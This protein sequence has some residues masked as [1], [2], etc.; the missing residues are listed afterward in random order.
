[1]HRRD[2]R[3]RRLVSCTRA[4]DAF[5]VYVWESASG[6]LIKR[7]SGEEAYGNGGCGSLDALAC[8]LEGTRIATATKLGAP[9]RI[10]T[11]T[12]AW[13]YRAFA[14][15]FEELHAN[16][17]YVER[18][19]EFDSVVLNDERG[20]GGTESIPSGAAEAEAVD[21]LRPHSLDEFDADDRSPSFARASIAVVPARNW[22]SSS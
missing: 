13:S 15:G 22:P 12:Q 9:I 16:V 6:S 17:V 3:I 19:D 7:I 10:W 11:A 8:E 2:F 21:V 18:E 5:E 1:M 20:G 14:P 4:A